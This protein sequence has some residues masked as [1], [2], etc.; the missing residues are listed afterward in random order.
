MHR[1][2]RVILHA[3]L[4]STHVWVLAVDEHGGDLD[5]LAG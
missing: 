3:W 5:E 2:E 1:W 4:I